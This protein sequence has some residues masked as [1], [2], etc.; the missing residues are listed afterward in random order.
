MG[1]REQLEDIYA[2]RGALTPAIIVEEATDPGSPLHERFEWDDT[3]AA[4]RYRERQAVDLIRSVQITQTDAKGRKYDVRAFLT[5][6][7]GDGEAWVYHPTTPL[8]ENPIT[9][10]LVLA[11][12]E[13]EWKEFRRRYENLSAFHAAI[14]AASRGDG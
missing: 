10:A 2:Q 7:R 8:L 9:A 14:E 13:R 4:R 12:F 11:E 6:D 5:V 1:L 3:E